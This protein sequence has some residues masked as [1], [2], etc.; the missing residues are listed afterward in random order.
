MSPV[1]EFKV[2]LNLGYAYCKILDFRHIREFDGVL[3]KVYNYI[4]DIPIDDIRNLRD[5][6]LLFG[7]RRM[8]WLPNT[9]GRGAWKFKGV[10][11]SEDDA[12]I[13]DFKYCEWHIKDG[14]DESTLDRWC[15]I[16][17]LNQS[18]S[19]YLPYGAISHLE[20]TIS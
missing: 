1:L 15:A 11:I 13:P 2:P 14:V 17:N 9:R 19:N 5:L 16:M 10:L 3:A 20:N 12:L 4:S 6:D 18:T 8:P 7:A